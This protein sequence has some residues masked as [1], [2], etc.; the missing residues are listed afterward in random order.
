MRA[1]GSRVATLAV[2]AVSLLLITS[3]SAKSWSWDKKTKEIS[4][5]EL[6]KIK[7][8]LNISEDPRFHSYSDSDLTEAV[9]KEI[10]SQEVP[11]LTYG[12]FIL[13]AIYEEKL[14]EMCYPDFNHAEFRH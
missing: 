2:I 10:D 13:N 8:E 7:A 12:V 11:G 5:D 1:R 3:T 4:Q 9:D 6:K 14:V